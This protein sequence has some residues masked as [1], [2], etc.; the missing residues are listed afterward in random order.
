L[1]QFS[2]RISSRNGKNIKTLVAETERNVEFNFHMDDCKP[3]SCEICQLE[4]SDR[5][6]PFKKKVDWILKPFLSTPNII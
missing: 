2:E 5:L 4:C 3:H 1:V 6:H